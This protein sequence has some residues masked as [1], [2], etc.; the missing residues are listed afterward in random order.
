M[1]NRDLASSLFWIG[2]GIV[3]CAGGLMHGLTRSGI[4]GPGC[5]PFI[6]G[7]ILVFLSLA[8]LFSTLMKKKE[9]A[10]LFPQR[11]SLRRL[12]VAILALIAYGLALKHVGYLLTTFLFMIFVLRLIEP[13]RWRLTLVFA[14]LTA[15]VSWGLFMVLKVELPRG[16]LG[17]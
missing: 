15:L 8:H 16:I 1:K 9:G 14:F 13:Q 12:L 7:L 4:P 2:F 17:I 6:V 11:D 3:F 5:L 10:N